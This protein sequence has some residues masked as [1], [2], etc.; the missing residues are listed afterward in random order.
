MEA[1][2]LDDIVWDAMVDRMTDE[3]RAIERQNAEL[4]RQSSRR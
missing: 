1:D 2:D 3:A 4:K